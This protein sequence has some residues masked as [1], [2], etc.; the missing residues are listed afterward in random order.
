MRWFPYIAWTI[1]LSS[2]LG[3][4]IMSRVLGFPP[5]ELCWYQRILMFPL[6]SILTVGILK[7]DKNLPLY[8]LPLSIAGLAVA[9]YHNLLYYGVIPQSVSPC[10]FGVSCTDVQLELLGFI[11]IPFL[12]LIAFAIINFCMALMFRGNKK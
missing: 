9:A 6:V 3:S 1:A 4:F 11:T 5:C 8:V 2:T 12:S 10:T 7:K